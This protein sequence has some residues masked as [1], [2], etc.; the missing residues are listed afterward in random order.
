[1]ADL[2][3]SGAVP[4]MIFAL[5]RFRPGA[6][7]FMSASNGTLLTSPVRRPTT[8]SVIHGSPDIDSTPARPWVAANNAL[9]SPS[10]TGARRGNQGWAPSRIARA[11]IGFTT[12]D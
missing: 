10:T 6:R 7:K 5:F 3:S 4:L 11:R 9:S 1:M 2:S 8:V 12:R